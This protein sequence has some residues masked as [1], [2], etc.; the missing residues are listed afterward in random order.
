MT[1][2]KVCM[3]LI[4]GHVANDGHSY[5]VNVIIRDVHSATALERLSVGSNNASANVPHSPSVM[6]GI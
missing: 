5:R 3:L 2:Y 6:N 1:G 4:K